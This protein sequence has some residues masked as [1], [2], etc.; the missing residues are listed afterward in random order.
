M[1]N[2]DDNNKNSSSPV[3]DSTNKVENSEDSSK[4]S[5]QSQDL[6]LDQNQDEPYNEGESSVS[7]SAP[8]VTSDDDTLQNAHNVGMQLGDTDDGDGN[9]EEL[10][11][12]RDID[13]AE[14]DL[15]T[16]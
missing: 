2:H 8:Y 10:D 13:K 16:H 5:A 11:I 1:K 3:L 12:A 9:R 4:N 15:R 7:G 14:E 6:N